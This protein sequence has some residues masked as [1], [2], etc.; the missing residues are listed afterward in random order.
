MINLTE[1]ADAT[2]SDRLFAAELLAQP[3]VLPLLQ[4]DELGNGALP[5][6]TGLILSGRG[7]AGDDEAG[8]NSDDEKNPTHEGGSCLGV[9][10]T[11]GGRRSPKGTMLFRQTD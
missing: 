5:G 10:R 7:S 6:A 11:G 3:L 2:V 1:V 8:N 9:H 4:L